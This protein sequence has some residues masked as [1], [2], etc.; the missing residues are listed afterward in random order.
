VNVSS[1]L[2]FAHRLADEADRMICANAD[3][4]L[5]TK[6]KPD[7]TFVTAL[8]LKIEEQ[9]R[10]LINDE[11]PTHGVWGEEFATTNV[12][13]DWVWTLDPI[14]GTMALVCGIP[15]YSTL[16]SLCCDGKPVLGIMHFPATR[17]RWVGMQGERT[18]FNGAVCQSSAAESLAQAIM[19]ASNPDFFKQEAEKCALEAMTKNTAWRV[20]GSAAMAYGRLASGRTHVALDADLKIYDYAPFVPIIEGAGGVISDWEGNALHLRSGHRVLAAANKAL[21]D[22]ALNVVQPFAR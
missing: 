22:L 7:K 10:S 20:Y 9:L 6:T 4:A 18:T 12:D 1:F 3:T 19:T 13:A 21:H 16:I 15:V 14:D 17:E 2:P 5:S 8:D 11:H